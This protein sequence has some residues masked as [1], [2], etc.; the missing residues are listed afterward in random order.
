MHLLI[1]WYIKHIQ[2]IQAISYTRWN[3]YR[4]IYLKHVHKLLL[5]MRETK[6]KEFHFIHIHT[7]INVSLEHCF[8]QFGEIIA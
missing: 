1:L 5:S 6:Y 3:L 4:L 7:S 2:F 8:A